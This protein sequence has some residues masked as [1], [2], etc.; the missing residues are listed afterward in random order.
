MKRKLQI[1][2]IA[3]IS[4]FF[5]Q[6][7]MAQLPTKNLGNPL[8]NGQGNPKTSRFV[9]LNTY[10]DSIKY[11]QKT[12]GL[13]I[14]TK[15]AQ[16]IPVTWY[17]TSDSGFVSN[18]AY[19]VEAKVAVA[20]S[21]KNGF[22]VEME[23]IPGKRFKIDIDTTAIYNMTYSPS[24]AKT[25]LVNNLDNRGMHTYRVAIDATTDKAYIYRDGIVVATAD[26]DGLVSS[27]AYYKDVEVIME[28]QFFEDFK[29]LATPAFKANNATLSANLKGNWDITMDTWCMM[30]IDTA[31]ANVKVGLTSFWFQNGNTG[32]LKILKKGLTAGKYKLSFWS[33]VQNT[34]EGYKGNI[35]NVTNPT[36]PIVL[37]PTTLLVP[38]N[39]NF[40]YREFPFDLSVDGDVLITFH[41]GWENKNVTPPIIN[42]PGWSSIWFDDLRIA[43]V[44][45]L[46]Y[47]RFGKDSEAGVTD[48]TLG[49]FTYDMTGAY[50]PD[51]TGINDIK[52]QNVNL[53]ATQDGNGKLN[54]SYTLANNAETKIQLLDLNG[55]ILT[56][57]SVSGSAGENA[58]TLSAS[59]NK[60]L[61]FIRLI[62]NEKTA[63][64]KVVLN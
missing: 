10:T 44:E 30:G 59:I 19:T 48:F 29:A 50:A 61:Y 39:K 18:G 14:L 52:M 62:A 38:G 43:K 47:V 8:Y 41:N 32:Q 25:V 42:N 46:P 24:V 16:W 60:G 45:P 28:D 27:T 26:V 33:K 5:I 6:A 40:N 51:V 49:S 13:N 23:G 21:M 37:L 17:A 22:S 57:Q 31:K 35:T 12:E 3:C 20:K 9:Q 63:T 36:A 55:R 34:W 15:G 56:S 58:T 7:I 64:I 1:T 4:L 11:T 54:V 2:L 53:S